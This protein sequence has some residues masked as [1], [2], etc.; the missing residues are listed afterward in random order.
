[1]NILE[2]FSLSGKSALITGGTKGL[3]K[4]MAEAISMAGADVCIIGRDE[5]EGK[6]TAEEIKKKTE[7][8]VIFIKGDVRKYEE[9]KSFVEET[10]N[11][12][13]KIDILI[14]SAGINFRYSAEDFPEREFENVMKT[15]F[16][17]TWYCCKEVGRHMIERK[18][19]RIITIGSILSVVTLPGRTP[20]SSSKGAVVQ[21][22][23]TL[24][25]E[26]AKYNITVNCIC[27]GPFETD[28]NREIFKKEEIRRFF[29]ERI[30]LGRFGNPEEVG[31]VAVFLSSDASSFITGTTIF[32]DGGWTAL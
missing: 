26:W 10:I 23:K 13:G 15:N 28:I 16:Y 14:T 21:L 17:G 31:L 27:P 24:A 25:V 3:G 6:K 32:I 30:P 19:G 8:K 22:T 29:L 5:K 9:V 18:Y 1:M 20:Y 11:Q 2:K 7:R 4:A 12:L